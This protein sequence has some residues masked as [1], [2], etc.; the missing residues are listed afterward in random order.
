MTYDGHVPQRLKT[1]QQWFAGIIT[2]PIDENS[3]IN[4]ISPSGNPIEEEADQYI[5]PSPTLKSH[6]R[7]Q[8]YNQQYWWRLLNIL[9]EAY[10]LL[11]RLFG[12]HDFNKTIG[13]PY[14]VKYY[15]NHWNLNFLGDRLPQWVE[16]EYLADDKPLIIE[17]AYIDWAYNDSFTV[18]QLKPIDAQTLP[19]EGNIE[20]L[21]DRKIYLQPYVNLFELGSNLFK[22]RTEFLKHDADYWLEHDFPP[23]DKD[24]TYYFVLY[25]ARK[26]NIASKEISS[27]EFQLLERFKEGGTINSAC[28][29]LEQQEKTLYEKATKNLHLWFQNWIALQWL[30]LERK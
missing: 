16:E 7:I 24:K 19:E 6:E 30:T 2:Q 21:L 14:L 27:G 12:Y 13:I 10:P 23:V 1:S 22:F 15:P 5:A 4:P 8:I 29:W 3:Q 25:R 11:V 18:K 9:Q 28:Q 17:S 26:N 20:S